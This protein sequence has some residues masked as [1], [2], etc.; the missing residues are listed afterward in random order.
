M[1]TRASGTF[2]VTIEPDPSF[3]S[4]PDGL[5]GRMKINKTFSGDLV[6]TSRGEMLSTRT[7][8]A[9]SAGYVA[10]ERVDGALQ[11]RH[12]TFV[13]QHSGTMTRGVPSLSVTVV[14]DSGAGELEGLAGEMTIDIVDGVHFYT[15]TYR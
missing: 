13:L 7:H 3:E 14:P 4:A 12:G 5:R 6:G 9:G 15:F 10:M 1:S 8:V 2:T 11:G